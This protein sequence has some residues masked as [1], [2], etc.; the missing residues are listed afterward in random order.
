M[1]NVAFTVVID[2]VLVFSVLAFGVWTIQDLFRARQTVGVTKE[3]GIAPGAT[4][5]PFFAVPNSR[6]ARSTPLIA[7]I[8]ASSSD[9][10]SIPEVSNVA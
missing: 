5:V 6:S 10:C 2:V 3:A 4:Y 1:V 8:R 7:S 9:I